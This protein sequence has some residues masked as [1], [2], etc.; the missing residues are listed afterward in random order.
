MLHSCL[1]LL[2]IIGGLLSP[3]MDSLG[4]MTVVPLAKK[5]NVW[6]PQRCSRRWLETSKGSILTTSEGETTGGGAN[7]LDAKRD[8]G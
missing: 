2:P 1:I 4:Y 5:T 8:A 6:I 7:P 3:R